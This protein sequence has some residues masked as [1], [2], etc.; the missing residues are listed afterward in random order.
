VQEATGGGADVVLD[1]VGSTWPGSVRASKR[2]GRIVVFGGTGGAEVTVPLRE[3]YLEWRS[4]L[5]T[6]MG[7][8]RDVAGLWLMLEEGRLRPVID[9][10]SPLTEVS[11]AHERLAGD[12]FGKLVLEISG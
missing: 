7:S 5:G 10:V 8:P 6:T 3:V 12:H 4:L 11:A 9:N 1:S 2:G